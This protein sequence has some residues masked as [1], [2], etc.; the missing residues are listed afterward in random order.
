MADVWSATRQLLFLKSTVRM[1][2]HSGLGP[3]QPPRWNKPNN[4]ATA[5]ILLPA[6][7]TSNGVND[8]S[9]NNA[10]QVAF[11]ASPLQDGF[12]LDP[13]GSTHHL[14]NL[15]GLGQSVALDTLLAGDLPGNPYSVSDCRFSI[16]TVSSLGIEYCPYPHPQ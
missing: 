15:G 14:G 4:P 12:R 13:D 9:L 5:L 2:R 7:A 6:G 10:G 1:R 8:N 11:N 16:G 3:F